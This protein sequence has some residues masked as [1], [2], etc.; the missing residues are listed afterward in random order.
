VPEKQFY[1]EVKQAWGN[2]LTEMAEW[3]WFVT[4]TFRDPP[5]LPGRGTWTKPGWGYAKKAWRE[6]QAVTMPAVDRRRWVRCFEMQE[7]RG[8]PHIH[9]LVA[10]VDPGIRRMDMVDWAWTNY[11]QAR[12]LPYD[13]SK[14]AGYYLCKYLSKEMSDIEFGGLECIKRGAI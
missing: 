7:W 10:G 1:T 12:I 11:G 6:F 3:E 2:W 14:G 9:A 13:P 8:V 4:M 5:H